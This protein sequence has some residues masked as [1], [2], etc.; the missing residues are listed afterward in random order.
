MS[1]I[2]TPRKYKLGHPTTKLE[3][4][5]SSQ[6]DS[7]TEAAV[8]LKMQVDQL[9]LNLDTV[10]KNQ[11]EKAQNERFRECM[12]LFLHEAAR[13]ALANAEEAEKKFA[14]LGGKDCS[15]AAVWR[16]VNREC[17]RLATQYAAKG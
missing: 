12:A 4:W 1:K 15:N 5:L 17:F 11:D 16:K 10:A 3:I 8:A 6:L 7:S 14:T 9:K 2:T 13:G